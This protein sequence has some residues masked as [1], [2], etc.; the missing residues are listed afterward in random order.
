MQCVTH[1]VVLHLVVGLHLIILSPPV[2]G[3]VG[4]YTSVARAS[5][6]SIWVAGYNDAV[7]S[8]DLTGLYGDLVVGKYDI[9]KNAVDWKTVD[10]VPARSDG[11]CPDHDHN[12]WRGGETDAG[13]DV[14]LW[15]SIAIGKGDTPMVSYYDQT[16][17]QLKFAIKG[18]D[19]WKTYVLKGGAPVDA[20]RYSKMVLD[21]GKPVVAFL[22]MEPGNGGKTRS[23]VS[24]VYDA[25]PRKSF[26]VGLK[27]LPE[28]W[29]VSYD[30]A[31]QPFYE[32]YVHDYKMG[33]AMALPGFLNP[34]RTTL[35]TPLD[36]FFFTQD[37]SELMGAARDAGKGQVVNL[38]VR[39]KVAD[40]A[41]PGMP[42]LGSGITWQWQGRTVMASPNLKEGLV[43]VIDMKDWT[44][45][46]TIPTG[47]E[48][49]RGKGKLIRFPQY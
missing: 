22:Q 40:L 49:R 20:G 14:G 25:A 28:I 45:L 16:H 6:G 2:A 3:L 48:T 24:A 11:T 1:I 44:T 13:D 5:D 9:G 41:L 21:G 27:D 23:R 39:K 43:T 26:I 30:P 7:L 15:T 37:Y 33:E 8:P 19:G 36:D 32:G 35:D 47:P 38:D 10:G 4:A 18:G 12:G 17:G 42:H 29:E 34:R 31:A 46:K